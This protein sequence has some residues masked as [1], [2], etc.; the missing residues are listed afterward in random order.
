MV[1]PKGGR[2]HKAPYE[3]CTVR[4]PV[5]IRDKVE[6]VV[7][8]YRLSVLK[9]EGGSV[10]VVNPSF[11]QALDAARKIDRQKK[12]RRQSLRKLL[13]VLYDV[14]ITDEMLD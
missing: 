14:E 10:R 8:Q 12:S 6:T 11:E 3:T 9:G 4:V 5:P 7:E 2:G 13:Q 1:L